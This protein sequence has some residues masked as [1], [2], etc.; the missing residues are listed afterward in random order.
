M[1][2]GPPPDMMN[3]Q[4]HTPFVTKLKTKIL[5]CMDYV[6]QCRTDEE[7]LNGWRLLCSHGV[8]L[9]RLA[10]EEKR[11]EKLDGRDMWVK[12]AEEVLEKWPPKTFEKT[13]L[14]IESND[15]YRGEYDHYCVELRSEDLDLGLR[16][17]KD[18]KYN[19]INN[20][21]M[22][23]W[24]DCL[25]IAEAVGYL[26]IDETIEIPVSRAYGDK[27]IEDDVSGRL[28]RRRMPQND[29]IQPR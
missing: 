4:M 20:G 9:V 1:G 11:L 21:L 18:E 17:L 14:T 12:L 13:S 29:G 2:M 7:A 22:G 6:L 19:V 28:L 3:L 26:D 10:V 27:D 15:R 16:S 23:L 8:A 25:S 5:Q 24:G